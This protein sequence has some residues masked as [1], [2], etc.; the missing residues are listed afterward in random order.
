M[1]LIYFYFFIDGRYFIKILLERIESCKKE[2]KIEMVNF[3]I[4][5]ILW[6]KLF[7]KEDD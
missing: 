1:V 2:I 3:F 6:D 7:I 4:E 5:N